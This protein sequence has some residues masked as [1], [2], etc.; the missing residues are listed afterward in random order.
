MGL[1]DLLTFPVTGPIKGIIWIA[2]QVQGLA[3][4][5]IYN[6]DRVRGLLAEL[7]LQYDMDE[8]SEETFLAAEEELLERL[9][10]IQQRNAAATGE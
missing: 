2:E 9:E 7:E 5:E 6:E 8:I 10:I 1:L 3:E 4:E